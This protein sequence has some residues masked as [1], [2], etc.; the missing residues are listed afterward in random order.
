MT[1]MRCFFMAQVLVQAVFRSLAPI[2]RGLH[3]AEGSDLGGECE[4]VDSDQARL[5][6]G[7]DPPDARGVP[8]VEVGRQA[9]RRG[10]GERHHF[11]LGIEGR[12]RHDRPECLF[13]EEAHRGI[14]RAHD[15]GL[16]E[17]A[18]QPCTARQHPGTFRDGIRKVLLDLGHGARVDQRADVARLVAART[19]AQRIH[20]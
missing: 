19:H 14:D 15:R 18:T 2:S 6:G 9:E 10:I 5:E 12:K 4:V 3:A 13:V 11:G 20:L 16:E 8:R 1:A 17:V 7:A